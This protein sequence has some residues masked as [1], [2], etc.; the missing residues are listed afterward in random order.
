MIEDQVHQIIV[1]LVYAP[2]TSETTAETVHRINE[3]VAALMRLVEPPMTG[4]PI[5]EQ[6][7]GVRDA[8]TMLYAEALLDEHEVGLRLA[9]AARTLEGLMEPPE[10]VPIEAQMRHMQTAIAHAYRCSNME[11]IVALEAAL[12][13]LRWVQGLKG[14][15]K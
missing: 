14:E 5:A 13:T 11:S 3:A 4:V 8:I 12:A 6:A 10:G 7:Q 2:L 1:D 15:S 9:G